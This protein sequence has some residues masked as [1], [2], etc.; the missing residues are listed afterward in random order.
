MKRSSN[1]SGFFLLL[2]LLVC[3][4]SA[5]SQVVKFEPE[6]PKYGDTVVVTYN[7]AAEGAALNTGDDVYITVWWFC[8]YGFDGYR[9]K[10]SKEQSVFKYK[11]SI[12]KPMAAVQVNFMTLREW[13]E[14]NFYNT[15][16]YRTDGEPVKG[17]YLSKIA[18]PS[19]NYAE[20]VAK[21]LA[22][23]P[24]NYPTYYYKWSAAPE[25]DRAKLMKEDMTRLL[26]L[27]TGQKDD[28]LWVLFWGHYLLKEEQKSYEVLQTL[29]RRY[30]SS[31][32]LAQ[33]LKKYSKGSAPDDV[34]KLA[35]DFIAR[36]PDTETAREWLPSIS[37]AKEFPIQTAETIS[38]KWMA[39]Q[40]DNP[41]P[42]LWLARAYLVRQKRLEEASVLVE[43]ALN[44]FLSDRLKLYDD[45]AGAQ[46]AD[47]IPSAYRTTAEIAINMR[48]YAKAL[49]AVRAAQTLDKETRSKSYLL[50]GQ[51][52]QQLK[53]N[54]D[55]A[56][57]AYREAWR[58]GGKEAEEP[59]KAL[60]QKQHGG[61]IGFDEYLKSKTAA[62]ERVGLKPAPVFTGKSINGDA[63][64]LTGLRGK[65]V[66]L[67][68][69]YVGCAPCRAEIPG[70]NQLVKDFHGK[71]V[72]FVA[73]ALDKAEDLQTFLKQTPF[74]YEVVPDSDKIAQTYEVMTYPTH[75]VIDKR[76]RVSIRQTGRS[77]KPQE[78]LRPLIEQALAEPL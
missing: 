21:E 63:I 25:A 39:K 35:W 40:A 55:R 31:P 37:L 62:V 71:D 28:L 77:S 70:L 22:L 53:T 76:G 20:F 65:V 78:E 73:F 64:D 5:T 74:D 69:W 13:K 2:T 57:T 23:Y 33:I 9:A 38:K 50:E 10:M 52:W 7:P 51:I 8:E 42:Y 58:L 36:F 1:W 46:T 18:G 75:V 6:K 27:N 11:F 19:R 26:S 34:R 60:Y 59:L 32:F 47:F 17:G 3:A 54:P 45:I 12:Q 30:P 56:E 61:L 24:D 48:N 66:V 72:V 4:G 68:F 14:K 67:N 43:K 29:H 15:L 49:S 16:I 41:L 44:L